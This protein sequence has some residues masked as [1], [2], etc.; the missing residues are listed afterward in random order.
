MSIIEDSLW[1]FLQKDS[2]VLVKV[3]ADYFD[4]SRVTI[5]KILLRELGLRKY[6]RRSMPHLLDEK[7]TNCWMLVAIGMVSAFCEREMIGFDGIATGDEL[8]FLYH[9]EFRVMF[10]TSREK[11]FPYV[12]T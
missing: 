3:I 5:K 12:L 10:A 2:F 1:T 7:Q 8:W 11:V 6:T 4:V 9:Y